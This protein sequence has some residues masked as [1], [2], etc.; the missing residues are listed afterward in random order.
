M[1]RLAILSVYDKTGI[2]EFAKFLLESGVKILSTGGTA[3]LLAQHSIP[4]TSISDYT[5]YPEILDGRVKSLHPMIHGGILARRNLK[6]DEADLAKIKAQAVDFVVVNLYPFTKRVE[7]IMAQRIVNHE[8]LV[9]LIDIGGPTLLRAAAKNSEFVTPICDPADYPLVMNELRKTKTLSPE[10]RRSL[11]GKVFRLTAGYDAAIARYFSLD[12]RLLEEDGKPRELAPVEGLIL[13]RDQE[14]RYGENPHQQAALYRAS[15]KPKAWVQLQG[16]ELSFN[17]LVDMEA[18]GELFL[19]LRAG[20]P[21]KHAAII[22]KHTNPCGA[23]VRDTALDAFRDARSC[24]PLSAFGGIIA[25]SGTIDKA[26][27]ESILEGFVEV[28]LAEEI[29]DAAMAAFAQKKNV[30]VIRCDFSRLAAEAERGR[31]LYRGIWGDF[32]LQT[33]DNSVRRLDASQVVTGQ[34]KAGP[35]LPDMEFAWRLCKHI[36]SNAIVIAKNLQAIGVGAGQMS[37]I[38]SARLALSRAAK[39]GFDVHGAVAA[40]DAFLPFSDTLETLHDAGIQA[41][42]QPGGSLKDKEVLEV[43]AKRGV[44]MAVTGERHF[45]H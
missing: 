17:N 16:K 6:Q 33:S 5:G 8:L 12:E 32:L 11:A 28:V 22:I 24:D 13:E 27:A 45:R 25:L 29:D 18:A 14:L 2:V 3:T 42:V 44:I 36:K 41:L 26:I 37:R 4:V 21:G 35:L 20:F 7:E 39:H 34:E 9:E 23:A 1:E 38:D 19:D 43:A 30:R 10:L 40:S 31:T 15:K